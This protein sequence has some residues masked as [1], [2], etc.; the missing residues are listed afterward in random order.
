M[1]SE[2]FG[3][4]SNLT[5][6]L[7]P[8]SVT[9]IG[10]QCFTRCSNL[11]SIEISNSVTS[12]GSSCFY[13]CGGLTSILIGALGFP[14][15]SSAGWNSNFITTAPNAIVTIFTLNGLETDLTGSP[16][17]GTNCTFIYERA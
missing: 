12:I 5:S 1:G 15:S 14:V 8:N 11:T 2:C 4:C 7:I 9:S 17:G 10:M 13:G 3:Y 16:W 6:I